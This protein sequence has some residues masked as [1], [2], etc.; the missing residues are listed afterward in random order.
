MDAVISFRLILVLQEYGLLPEGTY[1][2]VKG[3]GPKW[4]AELVSGI[5]WHARCEQKASCQTFLDATSAYDTIKHAGISSACSVFAVSADVETRIIS[6][7][8]G[9]SRVVNTAYGLEDLDDTARLEGGVAQGAPSSP[10]LYI[11]TTAAAQAYWDPVIKCVRDSVI[12]ILAGLQHDSVAVRPNYENLLAHAGNWTRDIFSVRG[13]QTAAR[14]LQFLLHHAEI[15]FHRG[16]QQ[17]PA[18]RQA[19]RYQA[20]QIFSQN[21]FSIGIQE[22]LNKYLPM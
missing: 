19:F 12:T 9:H 18:L 15:Q 17:L 1:G 13:D 16:K 4:P 21:D 3:G 6:H 8:G 10:L 5:Q 20:S 14:R 2:F 11:F 7:I 22:M